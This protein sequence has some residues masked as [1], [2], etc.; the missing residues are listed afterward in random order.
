MFYITVKHNGMKTEMKCKNTF[1]H[2][3]SCSHIPIENDPLLNNTAISPEQEEVP[4]KKN[5]TLF[6]GIGVI[7]I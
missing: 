3:P 7:V 5:L 2:I 1:N 4:K 6:S